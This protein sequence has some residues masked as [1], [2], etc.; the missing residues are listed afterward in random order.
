[1]DQPKSS[2]LAWTLSASTT[3]AGSFLTRARAAC[4]CMAVPQASGVPSSL[5][6]VRAAWSCASASAH[7]P[8]D[9]SSRESVAWTWAST[10]VRRSSE[11]KDRATRP[12]TSASSHSPA[13]K[14]NCE[15]C[16]S[17]TRELRSGHVP[18]QTHRCSQV[19]Y[20]WCQVPGVAVQRSPGN[21]EVD[22]SGLGPSGVGGQTAGQVLEPGRGTVQ[23]GCGKGR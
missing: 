21:D 7:C 3:F 4:A 2:L 1:M 16:R 22:V 13:S 14:S 23:H 15:R 11:S 8:R 18:G 10:Q 19:G 5:A 20:P 17:S 12:W 9:A 6:A